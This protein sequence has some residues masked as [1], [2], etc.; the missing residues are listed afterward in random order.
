VEGQ[1]HPSCPKQITMQKTVSVV[2][3]TFNMEA[4][5][6]HC[7]DSV[8]IDEA[9]DDIEIIVV[10]DGST[11]NSLSIAEA[12]REKYPGSLVLIDKPNGH[13]GSCVN[14]ALKIASGTYFRIL[15][16][17]D[18]FDSATF[19]EFI[20][21]LKRCN[22]DLIIT[23]FSRDYISGRRQ[24]IFKSFD[25]M[26]HKKEYTLNDY[27]QYKERISKLFVMH[28]MTYRK[29][30]FDRVNYLQ[31]EGICYTD[32]EYCFYPLEKV[33][34]VVYL[35]VVLYRYT[36]GRAGQ[37]VMDEIS[38]KNKNHYLAIAN[39]M[40]EYFKTHDTS[41]SGVK[42][43]QKAKLIQILSTYYNLVL[44]HKKNDSD[45]EFLR[46]FDRNLAGSHTDIF[47]ELYSVKYLRIFTPVK[48]W[49]NKG[50]YV[51]TTKFYLFVSFIRKIYILFFL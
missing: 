8:L 7:L 12:Y 22:A 47:D 1:R 19:V 29:E 10:N 38:I 36:I 18:C 51:G 20:K 39:K 26:I 14:A 24:I 13:Y 30:I 23:N 43:L 27:A 6:S 2:I 16:A 37:S 50:I 15:D 35:D 40:L 9:L 44:T 32:S 34:T 3:P 41:G 49:R 17:D 48:L 25:S 42:E 45:D 33:K 46:N 11:D 31:S 4:Y 28:S 5:L 21:F